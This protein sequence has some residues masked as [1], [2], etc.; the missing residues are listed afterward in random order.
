MDNPKLIH[1]CVSL[2]AATA[3]QIYIQNVTRTIRNATAK[4]VKKNNEF[5]DKRSRFRDSAV[6]GGSSLV[7]LM[8]I[9]R[10]GDSCS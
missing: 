10:M 7:Q 3:T 5:D 8:G 1:F 9:L 2:L 6:G 4:V